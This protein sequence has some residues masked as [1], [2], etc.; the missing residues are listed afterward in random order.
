MSHNHKIC[1]LKIL[2]SQLHLICLVLNHPFMSFR[3]ADETIF[4]TLIFLS[5]QIV[6][7]QIH[8]N[9]C[10]LQ[11]NPDCSVLITN[12]TP[13]RILFTDWLCRR[14]K[15]TLW[16][17][18]TFMRWFLKVKVNLC[19]LHNELL[20]NVFFAT[21]LWSMYVACGH[22]HMLDKILASWKCVWV[23]WIVWRAYIVQ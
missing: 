11:Y 8:H 16:C 3:T 21:Y 15:G 17:Q 1:F 6:T 20:P 9:M 19:E 12:Y 13:G 22:I 2:H 18:G 10:T 7:Q 14:I 5:K 4:Q 23:P